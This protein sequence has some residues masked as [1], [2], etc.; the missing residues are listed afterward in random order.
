A[1]VGAIRGVPAGVDLWYFDLNPASATFDPHM[2]NPIYR[3]QPD[4]FTQDEAF[5]VGADGGGDI[6]LAVGF[7]DPADCATK[8]P[9]LAYSS[10]VA[11]NISTGKSVDKGE[12]FQLN[13]LGNVT[14]GPPGDDRQW[15]EFYGEDSVYLLYRTLAPAVAQVQ[16]SNDG[17]FTY[18]PTSVIGT[19]GQVG[20]IDVHQATGTVYASGSSGNVCTGT[21]TETEEQA[22]LPPSTW[23]CTIA[24][25]DPGG[26]ANIFFVVKVAD[27]G[28]ENGTAYVI[29]SNG[30]DIMLS[31]STDVG[32]TWSNPVRVSNGIDTTTSL[33]PWMETG[34][35]PG[36]VGIVWFGTS[37]PTNSDEADWEVFYAVSQD[38]DTVNPTFRQVKAA[39]HFIH[40]SNISTGGTLGNANRN[41]IDYF[42]IGFDPHGAAV[43]AYT[44]DHNDFD[45]H[46]YVTR[47]I[48][49]PSI[50]GG[51]VP[52]PQEGANLPAPTSYDA[53][54]P[55]VIDFAQDVATGLLVQVP[56]DDP[57]DILSIDYS[58]EVDLT[59][60]LTLIADMVISD[61]STV[62]PE[63]NYRVNFTANAPYSEVSPTGIYT[64]GLSDRGD[65]FYMRVTSGADGTLG[66]TWGTAA[67]QSDGS[68]AYTPRGAASSSIDTVTETITFKIPVSELNSVLPLEATPVG[69]DS[70][71]VGLRGQAFTSG[72]NAKRDLTR[73]GT[74]YTLGNCNGEDD[75]DDSDNNN[76]GG[77]NDA[78]IIKVTGGGKIDGKNVNFGF[79]ADHAPGG[80]LNYQDKSV[81]M[82]LTSDT[83]DTFTADN[84][85]NQVTF[86]GTGRV[87][88]D[89]VTFLVTV[90]DNGEPGRDDTF[91]IELSNGYS[92]VGTLS[93]GNIQVHR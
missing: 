89:F 18:G 65:Q 86:T 49:G 2:R 11:A 72:A 17:G 32:E 54:A 69:D 48:G 61:L 60:G 13:P 39:D 1:Y 35:T 29:Y 81:K 74:Q 42:Q 37:N 21:P 75:D 59:D 30:K 62:V 68:I 79:K 36:S 7:M 58:C 93:G 24:A 28:T 90:T 33:F 84:A 63:S 20:S 92:K 52:A 66:T 38:A 55:E 16:R 87:G 5:S 14:G 64:F 78:P 47:Q 10:L 51:N 25:T 73:G 34:P 56:L 27:D 26:V 67:R 19:I 43:I 50:Y 80:N 46:T 76:G 8:T 40:G 22:G 77:E 88:N 53:D 57:L 83:I 12:N 4:S 23:S 70:I 41:L 85:N 9:Q 44:D 31:H 91:Q 3:G 82:H 6:D 71:L 15:H 45:G